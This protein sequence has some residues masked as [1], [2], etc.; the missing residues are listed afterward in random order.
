LILTIGAIFFLTM[1]GS[2]GLILNQSIRVSRA[3]HKSFVLTASDRRTAL[4]HTPVAGHLLLTTNGFFT[5][6]IYSDTPLVP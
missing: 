5:R 6:L 3:A 4:A 2:V 1:V